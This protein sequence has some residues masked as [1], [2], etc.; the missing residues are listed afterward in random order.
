MLIDEHN[1]ANELNGWDLQSATAVSAD[2]L[3][4]VGTGINPDGFEE[5]WVANLRP[6]PEP[7]TITLV[8]LAALP[9]LSRRQRRR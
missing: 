4:I 9:L 6:I 1:L 7:S 5:G 3:V 2:G 8:A